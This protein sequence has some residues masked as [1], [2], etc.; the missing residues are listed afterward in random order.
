MKTLTNA[1][2]GDSVVNIAVE[3]GVITSIVPADTAPENTAAETIDVGG[4]WVLPGLWDHHV[5]F[6]QHA[7]A[8]RRID[9]SGAE[10][11]AEAAKIVADQASRVRLQAGQ[12]LI[13]HGFRDGLWPDTPTA[14]MLDAVVGGVPALLISGDLHCAWLNT[15]ALAMFGHAGHPTGVLRE[16]PCFALMARLQD[17][18]DATLDEWVAD[19]STAAAARGVVG[20]VDMEMGPNVASWQRRAAHGF[21]TMRVQAGIY[22]AY[23]DEAISAG[24]SRGTSLGGSS[25]ITS[26]PFKILTDGSLNTRTAYCVDEYHGT[27]DHGLLTVSTEELVPLMMKASAAGIEPAV[28]AIGDEANRLVLNAFERVGCRGRIEHAQLLRVEDIPRFAALGVAASV[29]PEHAMDDRDIAEHHWAGRTDRAFVLRSLLDAGAELLLGS[30]APVAPLDPWVTLSA[31]VF[32]SRGGRAPWHPEQSITVAE[33]LAASTHNAVKV[34][35]AA[36]LIAVDRD[37]FTATGDQLRTMPVSLTL[38]AG[39]VTHSAS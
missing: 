34:G 13:G 21:A 15:A 29:Q 33:A 39:S 26:G 12:P 14:E 2:L 20:V 5:H 23:L 16:D 8:V 3:G 6:N 9:V 17:I 1:R 7:L 18:S 24:F 25:L 35:H 4:R 10:S 27:H 36:D 37:P 30:D 19:A 28:H 11:A 38:V 31:A 22:T 32:R